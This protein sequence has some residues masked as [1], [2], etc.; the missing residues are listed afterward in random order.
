MATRVFRGVTY[1]LITGTSSAD[2]LAGAGYLD[3]L[4]GNDRLSGRDG[5][6][7]LDGGPG[8]DFMDGAA[9]T[10]IYIVDNEGDIVFAAN[11]T[12]IIILSS[13]SYSIPQYTKRFLGGADEIEL[14]GSDDINALGNNAPNILIGN[15]GS[16][17]LD[18]GFAADDMRGGLGDDVYIVDNSHD[19]VT[20]LAD[21]GTDLIETSASFT[22]PA[23]VENI[24][25]LFGRN[26]NATGNELDNTLIGN[27]GINVLS[28][29]A[30]DDLLVAGTGNDTVNG[31]AGARRT[32]RRD[33]ARRAQRR[34]RQRSA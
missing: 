13:V 3:R 6:D 11:S 5:T 10:N 7:V 15:S 27:S 30:G 16:N 20:E 14:T 26:A 19:K 31:G 29:L 24:T 18:G 34:R 25:I 33:R 32:V 9:G 12:K 2:V 8:A 1:A 23:N 17:V 22:A 21:E 4:G 28:G